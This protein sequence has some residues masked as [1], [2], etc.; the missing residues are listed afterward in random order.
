MPAG[1]IVCQNIINQWDDIQ[2]FDMGETTELIYYEPGELEQLAEAQLLLE[3]EG[4]A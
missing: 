4:T 3:Q 2:R 1:D